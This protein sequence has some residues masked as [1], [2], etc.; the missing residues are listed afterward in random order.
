M[1][2]QPMKNEDSE[3]RERPVSLENPYKRNNLV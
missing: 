3:C 2:N 1:N